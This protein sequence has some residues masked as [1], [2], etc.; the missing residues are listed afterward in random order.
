MDSLIYWIWLSLRCGAGSPSG[1]YLLS[2]FETPKEI[3]DADR[4]ALSDIDGIPGDLREAL[5]D[6]DIE[7]CRRIAEYC[8]RTNVSVI[9]SDSALYPERLR[10]VHSKPLV[11]YYKGR[12]PK[13][14]T[15]CLYQLSERAHARNTERKPRINSAR[16]LPPEAR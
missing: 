2:K 12:L 13:S 14:T 10:S 4:E 9:T 8:Q 16:S 15:T 1:T 5:L 6:K 7:L 11:L 3:F